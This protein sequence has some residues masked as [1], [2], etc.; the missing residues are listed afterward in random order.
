MGETQKAKLSRLACASLVVGIL[1]TAGLLLVLLNILA[2]CLIQ[3]P[4][5]FIG[6]AAGAVFFFGALAGA[7]GWLASPVVLVMSIVAVVKIRKSQ[8]EL[9]G[10]IHAVAG[11]IMTFVP[12][13]AMTLLMN[14][15]K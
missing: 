15:G 4:S 14:M 1:P 5:D 6:L 10:A 8:G 9:R 2:M 12:A 11:V 13:V 3:S 7:V